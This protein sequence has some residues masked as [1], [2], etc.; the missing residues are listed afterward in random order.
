MMDWQAFLMDVV[1]HDETGDP[2]HWLVNEDYD[3]NDADE[4]IELLQTGSV[5]TKVAG[6]EYVLKLTVTKQERTK[7]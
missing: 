3:L 5:T 4:L 7:K 2:D 6:V 1:N